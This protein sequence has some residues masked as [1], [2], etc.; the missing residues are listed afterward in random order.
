MATRASKDESKNAHGENEIAVKWQPPLL[1]NHFLGP[2]DITVMVSG[3]PARLTRSS[4]DPSSHPLQPL[5]FFRAL[6]LVPTS[7]NVAPTP[8]VHDRVTS[9]GSKRGTGR[10]GGSAKLHGH[11]VRQPAN[12]RT[13]YRRKDWR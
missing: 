6:R 2:R 5:V 11:P 12:V 3:L 9:N 1:K 13:Q 4:P 10:T 8:R 7:T